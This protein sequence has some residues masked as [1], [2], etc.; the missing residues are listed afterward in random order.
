MRRLVSRGRLCEKGETNRSGVPLHSGKTLL[1][2]KVSYRQETSTGVGHQPRSLYIVDGGL[3]MTD[4]H[5]PID[6]Q[7]LVRSFRRNLDATIEKSTARRGVVGD[8]PA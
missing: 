6:C 7:I 1:T 2:A 4:R 3:P 8:R 5:F